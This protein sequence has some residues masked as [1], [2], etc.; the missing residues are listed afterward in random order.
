MYC[1]QCGQALHD[2]A[3][4]CSACRAPVLP[5]AAQLD[6]PQDR[7]PETGAGSD[8]PAPDRPVSA[9]PLPPERWPQPRG[10]YPGR[11][12]PTAFAIAALVMGFWCFTV[13]GAVLAL[14][15]GGIALHQIEASGERGGGMARAAIILGVA[16]LAVGVVAFIVIGTILANSPTQGP[17]FVY[18]G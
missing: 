3:R 16:G 5:A 8:V 13:I 2:L 1:D 6:Q 4:Y 7:S 12:P 10:P 11:P 9:R 15:F 14:I 18:P 17:P